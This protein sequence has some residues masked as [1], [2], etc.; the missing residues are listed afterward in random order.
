MREVGT[1]YL[2]QQGIPY[3]ILDLCFID[4]YAKAIKAALDEFQPDLV[5]LSLRNVD[6]VSYPLYTSY[7]AFYRQVVNVIKQ[8]SRA[9]VVIGGS[10]CALMPEKGS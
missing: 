10:A 6:N 5:G 4:D 3:R 2:Q 8:H 7:L 1:S 9:P